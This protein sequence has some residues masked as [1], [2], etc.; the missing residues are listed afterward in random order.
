MK[1]E[2]LT[3]ITLAQ[4]NN[5]IKNISKAELNIN[6]LIKFNK[7]YLMTIYSALDLFELDDNRIEITNGDEKTLIQLFACLNEFNR[8]I[9]NSTEIKIHDIFEYE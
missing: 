3:D 1:L 4:I 8:Q 7:S 9:N 6:D 5:C 2:K